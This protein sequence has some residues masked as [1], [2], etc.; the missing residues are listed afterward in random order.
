MDTVAPAYLRRDVREIRDKNCFIVI[1][2]VTAP[3]HKMEALDAPAILLLLVICEVI[4]QQRQGH[5]GYILKKKE[6]MNLHEK[7]G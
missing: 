7:R 3:C 5:M 1:S 4:R 2:H 6:S